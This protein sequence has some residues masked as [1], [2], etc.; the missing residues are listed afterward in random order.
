MVFD[1]MKTSGIIGLIAIPVAILIIV[2]LSS[3][4]FQNF[5]SMSEDK[6]DFTNNP[7]GMSSPSSFTPLDFSEAP[8]MIVAFSDYQCQSCKSW[9]ENEYP[10]ISKNMVETKKASIVFLDSPPVGDDSNLISQATFCAEDQGKYS[11]YQKILFDSQQEID[12]WAK[13]EQLKKF[14][15]GLELD[16]KSFEE[17]LNSGKYKKRV[18]DNT[19]YA[20]R[21][22]VV[23]IPVFKIVNYEGKEHVFKGD[24]SSALFEDV[25]NRF[26]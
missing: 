4:F 12:G 17:C 21:L 7:F 14:A 15:L 24:I 1:E 3:L 11:E 9:Y 18:L 5:D 13:S 20:K 6:S 22:G 23:E 19:D 16:L 2:F 25:I 26:Q 10:K 8:V